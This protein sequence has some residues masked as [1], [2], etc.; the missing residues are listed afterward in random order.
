M[1]PRIYCTAHDIRN[2]APVTHGPPTGVNIWGRGIFPPIR[3]WIKSMPII[4]NCPQKPW[5]KYEENHSVVYDIMVRYIWANQIAVVGT[6]YAQRRSYGANMKWIHLIHEI[7][8]E[9][10]STNHVEAHSAKVSQMLWYA[11]EKWVKFLACWYIEWF[12]R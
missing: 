12:M 8:V 5:G 10:L 2:K 7:M 9:K 11:V 4:S 1:V 6:I 3:S